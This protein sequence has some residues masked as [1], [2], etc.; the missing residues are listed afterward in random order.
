VWENN[1]QFLIEACVEILHRDPETGHARPRGARETVTFDWRP[2]STPLHQALG[3]PETD[4]RRSRAA[5]VPGRRRGAPRHAEQ[6]DR[7]MGHAD[8]KTAERFAG[9]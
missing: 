9:G 8:E 1:A 7:W 3:V 4:V 2:D 6:V 5:A